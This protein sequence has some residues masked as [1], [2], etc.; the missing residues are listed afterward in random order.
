MCILFARS[1]LTGLHSSLFL[2]LAQRCPV[3]ATMDGVEGY[4]ELLASVAGPGFA[5]SIFLFSQTFFISEPNQRSRS[6][7]I[8][9]VPLFSSVAANDLGT[10]AAVVHSPCVDPVTYGGS[11][12][13]QIHR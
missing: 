7:L 11:H 8:C 9:L 4:T 13:G 1:T 2:S 10:A 6:C 3:T 5:R 12:L